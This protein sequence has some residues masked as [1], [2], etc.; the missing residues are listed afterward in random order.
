LIAPNL[1]REE[2]TKFLGGL[3]TTWGKTW[4]TWPDPKT[5][6]PMG[7]P[8]LMWSATKD[9]QVS[10]KLLEIRDR[11]FKVSTTAMRR[12]RA[13]LGPI[14][15]IDAPKSIH[16]IGRQWTNEGSDKPQPRTAG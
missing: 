13:H 6:L 14:P 8:L 4:H 15:Q 5:A 10:E 7:E 3:L 12:Q 11:E 16:T 1:S 9:G 2:E